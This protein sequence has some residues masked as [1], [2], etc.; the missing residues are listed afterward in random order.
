MT[1]ASEEDTDVENVTEEKLWSEVGVPTEQPPD[2]P[3]VNT[4]RF[5]CFR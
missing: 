3:A 1:L 2:V 5:S 4:E